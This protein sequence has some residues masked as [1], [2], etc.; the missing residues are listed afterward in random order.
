[1]AILPPPIGFGRD[2]DVSCHG[3]GR[4]WSMLCLARWFGLASLLTARGR[5]NDSGD[6]RLCYQKPVSDGGQ[7]VGLC[8]FP[9]VEQ[10]RT[11][12]GNRGGGMSVSSAMASA[13]DGRWKVTT[14]GAW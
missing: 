5:N 8:E 9:T 12:H 1:M 13:S 3:W 6:L 2:I 11:A 14:G 10:G 4:I 7:C